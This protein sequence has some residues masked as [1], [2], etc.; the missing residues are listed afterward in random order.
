MQ[1][2]LNFA[3][4]DTS[5]FFR[6]LQTR[7][8]LYFTENKISKTGNA[9][10][11]FKTTIILLGYFIPF[12]LVL[13]G[14]FSFW[15]VVFLY[16]LM[17]IAV[18]GIGLCIMHDANHG[19]YSKNKK[20]NQL[21]SYSLNLIG[22]SSFTWKIQHNI[23]H[24][25]YPNVYHIDEDIHDKPF[26]RLSPHGKLKSYH[27]FQ[28]IYAF[29]LYGFSTLSWITVKDFRQLKLYKAEGLTDK[30]GFHHGR[31]KWILI[32]SKIVYFF[33]M[34]VLPVL[35]GVP[36]GAVLLGFLILH[37]LAGLVITIVFQLAHVVEG[38]DHINAEATDQVENTWAIHQLY[39]TA[40]FS[41]KNKL[42]TWCVGGLNYQIEHHLFPSICH[43]HYPKISEIVRR[44]VDEF[45]LPYYEFEAFHK[46]VGSHIKMLKAFG[47]GHTYVVSH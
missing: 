33:Y 5:Q 3:K 41:T 15:G 2:S 26:L 8:N 21:L 22:G 11:Y 13:L 46:A 44:T 9:L 20:I 25:T 32:I 34:L 47:N 37:L 42:I 36:I 31:E 16:F 24:H 38:P 35:L 18:S 6:T 40:N 30:N 27:R 45:N 19:S 12:V 7:V 10:M 23:L 29:L 39:S 4:R 1:H 28:H 17:G 43:I 14:G